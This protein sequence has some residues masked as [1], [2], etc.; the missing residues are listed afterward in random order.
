MKVLSTGK[1]KGGLKGNQKHLS[2]NTSGNKYT[3]LIYLNIL[4]FTVR[5]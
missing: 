2:K 3:F 4:S 1:R 5:K